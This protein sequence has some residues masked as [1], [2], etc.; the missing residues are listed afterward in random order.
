M[1]GDSK[2]QGLVCCQYQVGLEVPLGQ[3]GGGIFKSGATLSVPGGGV[4]AIAAAMP[5]WLAGAP[6]TVDYAVVDAGVN[7][8]LTFNA[9]TFETSYA[10]ILDQLHTKW[11]SAGVRVIYP[12]FLGHDAGAATMKTSIDNVL[13]TRA[14]ALPGA[15]E[16]VIQ[17]MGPD[18]IHPSDD[19]YTLEAVA[20]RAT[21]P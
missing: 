20:I 3:I 17:H 6:V 14:W 11:P 16:F 18:G 8:I 1:V 5:A 21:L 15:D 9:P 2:A 10:S 12:W 19:G 4:G 7:D 13:S